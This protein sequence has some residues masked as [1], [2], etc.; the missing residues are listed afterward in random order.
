MKHSRIFLPIL[1]ASLLANSLTAEDN[2]PRFRGPT[3]MGVVSDDPRLP[4]Q[5]SK[6]ENVL[7]NADIPGFG[8]SGPVV[9]GNKVFLTTVSSDGDFEQPKKGLY[10]GRGRKE[11]PDG[12]H[13]WLT[14][15]LDI[16]TGKTLWSHEA[17]KGVPPVGR[18]P[19]ST[20]A[21][22][23]PCTDGER[24]YVLFG[25]MGLYCYDLD[26]KLLWTQKIAPKKTQYD[27]GAAASPV[28][29]GSHV[30]VVYDNSEASYIAAYDTKT[31]KERWKKDRDEKSTWATPFVWT[32][33]LR[34]EVVVAG[35]KRIRSYALDGNLLWNMDGRMSVLTIPSPFAANGMVYITS[36]YFQDRKRPVWVIKPGASG[37][38]TI[39]EGETQS[40]HV[41]WHHPTL[42]PF[43]TSPIVYGDYYYTLLDQGMMT[44]HLAMTGEAVYDRTR[45]PEFSSFTASPWAY[46]GK[47][48][49]LSEDGK[50]YV[51]KAG[52]QFEILHTNDLDE[53]SIATPAVV[54]GKLLI[55]T[56]SKIY[57]IS[58]QPV[59]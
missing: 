18:H 30:F 57:C 37:D 1:A 7:W 50:T 16:N 23:T 42:G 39:E 24:L 41:Q 51:V 34:T 9:W 22:E 58:K 44:C 46:N 6:T 14:Y 10:N 43:N 27:Y 35:R 17:H 40:K 20:Y 55:R 8:W 59:L 53:L 45:F 36:G 13:R 26:G 32:N 49:C 15:C 12:I 11:I 38:I 47:I 48:F 2:W 4:E 52:P 5:W 21:S 19:K 28:V 31:G 29:H 25:D 33:D 56:A 54:Q 3:A